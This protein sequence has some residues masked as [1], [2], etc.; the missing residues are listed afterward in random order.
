MAVVIAHLAGCRTCAEERL[1]IVPFG[2]TVTGDHRQSTIMTWGR[3]LARVTVGGIVVV[4]C[5]VRVTGRR[6][7]RV[8]RVGFEFVPSLR[9]LVS[10][11]RLSI[12]RLLHL[13]R[14]TYQ[15]SPG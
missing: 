12:D 2:V 7:L 9:I 5:A 3:T 8:G 11:D 13:S 1:D 6:Y 4:R 15:E 14:V 10:R